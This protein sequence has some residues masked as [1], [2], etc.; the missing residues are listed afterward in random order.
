[1]QECIS[2]QRYL[3]HFPPPQPYE[4]D[5]LCLGTLALAGLTGGAAIANVVQPYSQTWGNANEREW[6]SIHSS[7]PWRETDTPAIVENKFGAG[8]CVY[9]AA[10]IETV[11]SEGNDRL[12]AH[13]IRSLAD[14]PLSFGAETYPAIQMSVF[15]Q[16]DRKRLLVC[17]LNGQAVL[18]PVPAGT[19]N[20]RVALPKGAVAAKVVELPGGGAVE[21][22]V[23][24]G[25]VF[26]AAKNV[27]L[28][29]MLAVDY[30]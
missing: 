19:V 11:E 27:E 9:C 13:L 16:A 28:F 21:S 23:E 5:S 20:F 7:P 30:T 1:L 4:H 22:R 6:V 14:G 2:P 29:A 25:S 12:L 10:D 26:A 3:S 17:L 24:N 18:P 8:R 15:H